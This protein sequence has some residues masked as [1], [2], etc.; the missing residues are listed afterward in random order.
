MI[1]PDSFQLRSQVIS[2]NII[3]L[4]EVAIKIALREG[5]LSSTSSSLE[6]A[7]IMCSNTYS[8]E[9]LVTFGLVRF[10]CF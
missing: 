5:L 4:T 8:V 10:L 6:I 7:N 2:S 3:L 1:A 9:S